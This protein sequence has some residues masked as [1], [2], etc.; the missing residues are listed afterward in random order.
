MRD[1]SFGARL[2][3]SLIALFCS[4]SQF[5]QFRQLF[6]RPLLTRGKPSGDTD[7]VPEGEKR[8]KKERKPL[9]PKPWLKKKSAAAQQPAG[10]D[11]VEIFMPEKKPV[12]V[13]QEIPRLEPAI[14]PFESVPEK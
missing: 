2:F 8:E 10:E 5:F 6:L 14:E 3:N 13:E 9:P 11:V 7:P 4:M 12:S 1:V